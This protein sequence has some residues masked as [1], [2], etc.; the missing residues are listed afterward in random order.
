MKIHFFSLFFMG[1]FA[2][3]LSGPAH[4]SYPSAPASQEIQAQEIGK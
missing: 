4:S 1:V 3:P 2:V